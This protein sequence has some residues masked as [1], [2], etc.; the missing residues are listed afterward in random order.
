MPVLALG[1]LVIVARPAL[2]TGTRPSQTYLAPAPEYG[3]N[4]PA[5]HVL[6]DVYASA[7]DE[8]YNEP[9]GTIEVHDAHRSYGTFPAYFES[10]AVDAHRFDLGSFE[11]GTYT[12]TAVY[13]GDDTFAPSSATT[14]FTVR[15]RKAATSISADH[16]AG[17]FACPPPTASQSM[18]DPHRCPSNHVAAGTPITFTAYVSD[19]ESYRNSPPAPRGSVSFMEGDQVRAT[20]ALDARSQAQWTVV[21]PRGDHY[22][23]SNY[24]GDANYEPVWNKQGWMVFVDPAAPTSTTQPTGGAPARTNSG[25]KPGGPSHASAA[26]T[27]QRSAASGTVATDSG[28]PA[29][30]EPS[31]DEVAAPTASNP[32]DMEAEHASSSAAPGMNITREADRGRGAWPIGAAAGLGATGTA[33]GAGWMLRR[34]RVS[35]RD[36]Q[37]I[38][39]ETTQQL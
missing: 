23:T 20:L 37:T 15:Q 34:R 5:G 4:V 9:H 29:T 21:L 17:P 39:S 13:S 2:A 28:D 22:I 6:A 3:G 1:A 16:G 11:P 30:A 33:G 24:L 10:S 27:S 25:S 26:K 8:P 35:F 31:D 7:Q 18:N 38:A 19:D 12:L 32:N 36:L 14:T